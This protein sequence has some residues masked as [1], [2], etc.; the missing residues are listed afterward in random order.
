MGEAKRRGNYE[1]VTRGDQRVKEALAPGAPINV[2]V[3][4]L[5]NILDTILSPGFSKRGNGPEWRGFRLE[6]GLLD[7]F[8]TGEVKRWQCLVC[9]S[10]QEGIKDLAC[11]AIADRLGATEKD[12]GIAV[13][14]C[15]LCGG[16]DPDETAQLVARELKMTPLQEGHA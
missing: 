12:A 2:W 3:F 11:V 1:Q 15:L 14:L 5:Q 16:G 7:R 6:A 10:P 9:H 13:A 8:R 4:S